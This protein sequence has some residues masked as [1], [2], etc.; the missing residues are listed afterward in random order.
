MRDYFGNDD[1]IQEVGKRSIFK[2][3]N[4]FENDEEYNLEKEIENYKK[5]IYNQQINSTSGYNNAYSNTTYNNPYNNSNKDDPM[6]MHYTEIAKKVVLW[7]VF[8]MFAVI[9]VEIFKVNFM[10]NVQSALPLPIEKSLGSNMPELID[11]EDKQIYYKLNTIT[12]DNVGSIVSLYKFD[13]ITKANWCNFTEKDERFNGKAN[14]F[15]VNYDYIPQS[16]INKL[17]NGLIS[18]KFELIKEYS[19]GSVYAIN[20]NKGASL[21]V[22]ISEKDIIYGMFAGKYQDLFGE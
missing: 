11:E 18:R 15:Q 8:I 21:F 16:S 10:L 12:F 20:T 2:K 1:P 7:I 5:S 19:T 9:F 22:L 3:R 17:K 6:V 4:C 13:K 14:T